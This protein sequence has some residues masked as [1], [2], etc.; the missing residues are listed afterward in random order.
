MIVTVTIIAAA[1]LISWLTQC[2]TGS[3]LT[4]SVSPEIAPAILDIE[5]KNRYYRFHENK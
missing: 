2:G 4:I 5:N 3:P 1:S